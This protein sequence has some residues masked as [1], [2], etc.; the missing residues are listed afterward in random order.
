MGLIAGL[1]KPDFKMVFVASLIS[2]NDQGVQRKI[3]QFG[4]WVLSHIFCG[5]LLC[6][7]PSCIYPVVQNTVYIHT[8]LAFSCL[9]YTFNVQK[10]S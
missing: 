1:V 2:M 3:S 10:K 4:V 6:E 5:I 7:L 9:E 8:T